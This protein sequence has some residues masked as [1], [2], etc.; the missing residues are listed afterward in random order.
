[1]PDP[2]GGD[3][4]YPYHDDGR[5]DE[6]GERLG[7]WGEPIGIVDITEP[8]DP[9]PVRLRAFLLRT[10]RYLRRRPH[11]PGHATTAKQKQ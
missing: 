11:E 7:R 4:N 10:R 3:V 2:G 5:T 9:W 1:M 6:V 8:K